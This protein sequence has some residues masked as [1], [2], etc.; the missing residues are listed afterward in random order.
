M[1]WKKKQTNLHYI[2][3]VKAERGRE[4]VQ[5]KFGMGIE[6]AFKMLSATKRKEGG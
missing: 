1:N 3:P 5:A 6:Q 2:F 4:V